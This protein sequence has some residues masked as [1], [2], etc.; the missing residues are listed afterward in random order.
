MSRQL[1][2][3]AETKLG[4]LHSFAEFQNINL[5]KSNIGSVS[6]EVFH[7]LSNEQIK[8]TMEKSM[9][10]PDE[11]R[12]VMNDITTKI[13]NC[14]GKDSS[15]FSSMKRDIRA[16]EGTLER[17][18]MDLNLAAPNSGGRRRTRRSRTRRNKRTRRSRTHR[19]RK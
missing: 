2:I 18:R 15:Y 6:T 12:G 16:L 1:L 5:L 8:K 19:S 4:Q 14:D 10:N 3:S 11:V 13:N 7:L 9:I 17:I